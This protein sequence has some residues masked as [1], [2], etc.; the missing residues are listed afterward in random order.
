MRFATL[1]GGPISLFIEWT[2]GNLGDDRAE[3][4]DH[5]TRFTLAT[6]AGLPGS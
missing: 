4:A 2:E 3:F 5:V 1:F 6:L